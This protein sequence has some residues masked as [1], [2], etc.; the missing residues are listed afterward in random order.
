MTFIS[1][2]LTSIRSRGRDIRSGGRDIGSRGRGISRL[3]GIGSRGIGLLSR[4][5]RG[6]LKGHISN[7]AGLIGGSV[8]GGL[9][10]AIRES[11]GVGPSNVAFKNYNEHF[12]FYEILTY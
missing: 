7:K 11:N 6:A 8:S 12:L 3:R 2:C 5:D 9:D 1:L 4:V 10:T